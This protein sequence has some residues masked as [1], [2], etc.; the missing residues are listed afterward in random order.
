MGG[1]GLVQKKSTFWRGRVLED[2]CIWVKVEKLIWMFP[3]IVGTSQII[4]FD[5]VFQL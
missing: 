3:K 1:E 2:S 4:H 5:R